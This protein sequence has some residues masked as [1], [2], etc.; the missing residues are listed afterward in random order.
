ADGGNA[1]FDINVPGTG[2][3]NTS[4][5]ATL[6]NISAANLIAALPVADYLPAGVRDFS[7]QTSGTVNITGL[8]NKAAGDIDLKSTAGSVSGQAFDA[9]QAKATFQGTLITLENLEM[10]SADG[11]AR[12]KGTYDRAT[13]AFDLDLEGKNI[14]LA[15]LRN[16][17]TQNG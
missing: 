9:F 4:V 15:G 3:D 16:A 6:T 10:R 17:L 14:E 2:T 12:A 13:T 7:A 1:T 5:K 11:Y 8:P